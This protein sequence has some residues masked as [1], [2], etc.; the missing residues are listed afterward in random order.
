MEKGWPHRPLVSASNENTLSITP[1]RG[2]QSAPNR[3]ALVHFVSLEQSNKINR[4]CICPKADER[5]AETQVLNR[6]L[7]SG[8]VQTE[9]LSILVVTRI[10]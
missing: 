5:S 4:F 3:G 10:E 1:P 2:I 8:G 7:I 9:T 6:F